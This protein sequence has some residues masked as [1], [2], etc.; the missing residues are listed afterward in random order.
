MLPPAV[1]LVVLNT[2]LLELAG[3]I[4]VRGVVILDRDAAARVHWVATTHKIYFDELPR[5][6]QSHQKFAEALRNG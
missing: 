1:D 5:L 2:S 6:T 3:R 4:A